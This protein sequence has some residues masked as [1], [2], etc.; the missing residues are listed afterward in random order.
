MGITIAR[1]SAACRYRIALAL[2][3]PHRRADELRQ[4][5]RPEDS[6]ILLSVRRD[7]AFEDDV[8]A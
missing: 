4:I 2:F 5:Y 7:D 8:N 3:L 1:I 6:L